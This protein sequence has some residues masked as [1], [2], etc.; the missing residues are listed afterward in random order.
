[1]YNL[2]IRSSPVLVDM[3]TKKNVKICLGGCTYC[4][5][6]IFSNIIN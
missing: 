3:A 2:R 1:M 4:V 5:Y 6:D